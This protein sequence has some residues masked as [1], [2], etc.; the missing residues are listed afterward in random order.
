M[1]Q[2]GGV[3]E[4]VADPAPGSGV[5]TEQVVPDEQEDADTAA[6]SDELHVSEGLGTM[7]PWTSM[8]VAAT[9]SAVPL[10]V[11]KLV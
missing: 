10:V 5:V 4:A 3:Q 2:V 7:Q 6:G 9:D 8:A 11:A 1:L